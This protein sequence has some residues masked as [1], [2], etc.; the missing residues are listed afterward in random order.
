MN[1]KY[2]Y[3]WRAKWIT[4]G[5]KTCEE[6][7]RKLIEAAD[8]CQELHNSGVVLSDEV[9]DDYGFLYTNDDAVADKFGFDEAE[10]DNYE[11]EVVD[12]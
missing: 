9:N 8:F 5:C 3:I 10:E 6:M 4:D 11:E 7:A 1:Y 12:E 2:E